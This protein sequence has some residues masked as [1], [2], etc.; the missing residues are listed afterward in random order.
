MP[1]RRFAITRRAAFLGLA[2]T[3]AL[4]GI[5]QAQDTTPPR[6][7]SSCVLTPQAVEGPFY[8]D[9]K[10]LRRDITEKQPGTPLGLKLV[11]LD[12][13]SCQPL[14]GARIDVWHARA[15]GLYSGYPGQGDTGRIDT[16]GGTFMR[17][18]QVTDTQGAAAFLTVYPGWYEGRT[19]HI[20]FKVFLD[21][22]S[23][24]VG[25][26]YFPDA[27]SQYIYDNVGAYR[28]KFRR[29]VFNV[30]DGLARMDKA[31]GGFC[32]IKEEA[33]RYQATLVIGVD[34]AA[35]VVADNK[36]EFPQADFARLPRRVRPAGIVPG[37]PRAR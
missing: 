5:L 27:L 22:K 32:D 34:R 19:T 30:N 7:T 14:T 36:R 37:G 20:H 3:P 16:R 35:T 6:V 9:P 13:A 8:F 21:D 15:D 11:A 2:A 31:H 29:D 25:Q 24:L 10:L 18:S 1:S 28:R 33:D 17:G 4:P 12:S 26:I 23:V